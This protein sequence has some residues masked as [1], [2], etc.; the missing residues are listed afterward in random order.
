M[1]LKMTSLNPGFQRKYWLGKY[2]QSPEIL[3][4]TSQNMQVWF[5]DLDFGTFFGTFEKLKVGAF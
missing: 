5:G 4:K 2:A 3:A 1:V